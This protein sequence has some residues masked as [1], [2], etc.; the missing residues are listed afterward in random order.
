MREI[1]PPEIPDKCVACHYVEKRL[2]LGETIK[3]D[4]DELATEMA[5]ED[6]EALDVA[7]S[8][9]AY[10]FLGEDIIDGM[11]DDFQK[12]ADVVEAFP[13]SADLTLA[14]F[15]RLYRTD[16]NELGVRAFTGL[17]TR[18]PESLDS[19]MWYS[20]SAIPQVLERL[21]AGLDEQSPLLDELKDK[22]ANLL[23]T[24]ADLRDA[25]YK[26]IEKMELSL[27]KNY[28]KIKLAVDNCDSGPVSET[29]GIFKKRIV[30]GCGTTA[31]RQIVDLR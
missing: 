11:Q 19:P 8:L 16:E 15:L 4:I 29:K 18:F 30:L 31:T 17:I 27:E 26:N 28:L 9:H 25:L 20:L 6:D 5:R 24:S 23:N 14:E 7:G 3:A 22:G 2:A 10:S 13:G 21:R 1:Y 12:V